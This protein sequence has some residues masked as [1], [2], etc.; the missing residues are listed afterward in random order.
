MN[1]NDYEEYLNQLYSE[2]FTLEEALYLFKDYPKFMV[3]VHWVSGTLGTYYRK[4]NMTDFLFEFVEGVK[5]EKDS[6]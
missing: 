6:L 1:A 5:N 4:K 2:I 3:K